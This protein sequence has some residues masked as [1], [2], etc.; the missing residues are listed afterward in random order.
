MSGG[1]QSATTLIWANTHCNSATVDVHSYVHK[2]N[3]EGKFL[4]KKLTKYSYELFCFNLSWIP[5]F[6]TQRNSTEICLER[7]NV[8][9]SN[10]DSMKLRKKRKR[11]FEAVFSLRRITLSY[12]NRNLTLQAKL[13]N[14]RSYFSNENVKIQ[15]W[16]DGTISKMHSF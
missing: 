15:Y 10:C 3:E 8:V 16:Y 14:K 13:F 11:S 9:W 12:R 5:T 7:T 6:F 2:V 4:T 1:F